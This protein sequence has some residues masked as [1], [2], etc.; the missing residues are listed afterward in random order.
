V[1]EMQ[2]FFKLKNNYFEF[3][4]NSEKDTINFSKDLCEYI[5]KNDVIVLNGDL[6]TGKTVIVKAIANFFNIDDVSSPTFTIVNE[7]KS[8]D[9]TIFHFDVY[10]L[11]NEF[12]FLDSIRR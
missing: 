7:Y 9:I 2:D 5:S 6:G 4:S 1:N 11:K 10:K 8:D 3:I 12:D